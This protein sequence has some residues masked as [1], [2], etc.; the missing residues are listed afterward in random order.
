MSWD[1]IIT[2]EIRKGYDRYLKSLQVLFGAKTII[3]LNRGT[4]KNVYENALIEKTAWESFEES[5]TPAERVLLEQILDGLSTVS[6]RE[7]KLL[8]SL[9]EKFLYCCGGG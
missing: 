9:Y 7:V 3:G 5:L 2:Q 8:E 4:T 1:E 6:E